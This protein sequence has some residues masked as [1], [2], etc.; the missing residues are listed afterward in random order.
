MRTKDGVCIYSLSRNKIG[1]RGTDN[2]DYKFLILFY[3]I[4][5]IMDIIIKDKIYR[6][7]WRESIYRIWPIR[8][9]YRVNNSTHKS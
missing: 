2:E 6:G 8:K 7:L 9:R 4:L 1:I 5:K 3:L